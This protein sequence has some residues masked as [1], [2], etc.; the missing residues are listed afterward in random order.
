MNLF[1]KTIFTSNLKNQAH[2][3]VTK[4][5]VFVEVWNKTS[6]LEVQNIKR[7]IFTTPWSFTPSCGRMK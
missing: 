3:D 2:V 5:L 1:A 4:E 6:A 7:D